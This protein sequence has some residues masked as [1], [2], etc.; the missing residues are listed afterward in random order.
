MFLLTAPARV[1]SRTRRRR[2][3]RRGKTGRLA[4][5]PAMD[6]KAVFVFVLSAVLADMVHGQCGRPAR[7]RGPCQL[8][9]SLPGYCGI[10]VCA[11][12]CPICPSRCYYRRAGRCPACA[13][14]SVCYK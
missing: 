13:P 6:I 8:G 11:P 12:L 4:S 7:C 10:C 14:A 3:H 9:L 2:R 1:S 5:T